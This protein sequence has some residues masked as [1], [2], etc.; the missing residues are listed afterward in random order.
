MHATL[1]FSLHWLIT[2]L[3]SPCNVGDSDHLLNSR[4][5]DRPCTKQGGE[6]HGKT[7]SIHPRNN[8]FKQAL[9]L[10]YRL[11]PLWSNTDV[12]NR[13]AKEVLDELDVGPTVLGKLREDLD[14]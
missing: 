14:L 13:N 10:L 3:R 6:G 11:L 7:T 2:F 9:E 8:A 1:D 5:L 12:L 4:E